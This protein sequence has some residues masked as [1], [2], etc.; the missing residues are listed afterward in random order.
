MLPNL[1]WVGIV[2][3]KRHHE[4]SG[5]FSLYF[6]HL[7]FFFFFPRNYWSY[8]SGKL[9]GKFFKY[10]LGWLSYLSSSH[11]AVCITNL[12][13]LW[14]LCF[15]I[16]NFCFITL[17]FSKSCLSAF[18]LWF[19]VLYFWG[20]EWCFR[21]ITDGI[22]FLQASWLKQHSAPTTGIGFSPSNDKVSYL[23]YSVGILHLLAHFS[24]IIWQKK[25]EFLTCFRC[26]NI[27]KV[28]S[29]CQVS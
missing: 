20:F 10:V 22:S 28:T 14:R 19:Y 2:G 16:T 6:G 23:F 1:K 25:A 15:H 4:N 17:F 27:F 8:A 7:F 12:C 18:F 29:F 11:Y 21:H 5:N 13:T 26:G 24:P 9:E 3:A